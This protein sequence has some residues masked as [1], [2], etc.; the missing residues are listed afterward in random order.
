MKAALSAQVNKTDRN[1]TRGIAQ[2][3][4]VGLFKPV[5]VKTARSQEIR[6]LLTAHG[7]LRG[8]LPNFGLKV[9]IVTRVRFDQRVRE[10]LE[11]TPHENAGEK[12]GH[13]SG[14]MTLLRAA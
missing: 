1:D 2:M 12:V 7:D 11:T 5:H 13:G 14:G 3:M 4:R 10:L 6:M 8:I 9:G